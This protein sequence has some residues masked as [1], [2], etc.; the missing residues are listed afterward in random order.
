MIYADRKTIF[1]AV[2]GVALGVVFFFVYSFLALS[3]PGMHNSPDENSNAVFSELLAEEGQLHRVGPLNLILDNR[4]HPRSVKV[5]DGVQVPGGFLGLPILYGLVAKILGLGVMDFLTPLMALLGV[6]AWG[7]MIRRHFGSRVGMLAALLLLVNPVWWYWSSRLM[8]PNVLLMSLL[9][10]GTYLLT[11]TPI[12]TYIKRQDY[13]GLGLLQRMDGLLA[14]I[15][16]GLALAVRPVAVYWVALGALVLLVMVWRR[17]PWGRML[18]CL[19][20]MALTLAPFLLLNQ[21][22]YGNALAS[23]YGDVATTVTDTAHGG[24]GARLLGPVRPILFPLGFAPR[25]ALHNFLVYGLGFFWWWTVVVAA[26]LAWLVGQRRRLPTTKGVAQAYAAVGLVIAGWLVLFYGSWQVP[27]SP[28]PSTVTIGSSYLRYWLPLFV[29]ATLPVALAL[30]NLC[31][32]GRAYRLGAIIIVVALSVW[33]GWAVFGS[34]HEGLS[35]VRA[36]LIQYRT[37]KATVLELTAE[38][39]IIVVDQA[40]KYLF[41]DREVLYP[42]RSEATYELLPAAIN[43]R[44]TY[45]F[46]LTLPERDLVWLQ[47]TKLVPFGLTVRSVTTIGDKSLYE[48]IPRTDE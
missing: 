33:S 26:A 10:I 13:G 4:V 22:L 17:I 25:V 11:C 46:G 39:A 31:R 35:K 12:G 30:S 8:M 48:F 28:D 16:F 34:E 6:L 15:F 23:G 3:V 24:W 21:S 14:G 20:F 47:D 7:L 36:N 5:V 45:Y 40:D 42:L 9:L 29:L 27:D 18:L 32:R 19:V 38:D 44:P 43:N 1:V 2:A 41:P 37:E